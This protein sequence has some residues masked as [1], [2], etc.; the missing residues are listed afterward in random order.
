MDLI[1]NKRFSRTNAV[2]QKATQVWLFS[3]NTECHWEDVIR[4]S[5]AS[6]IYSKFTK[7]KEKKRKKRER[8]H[9]DKS[10][11]LCK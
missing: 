5:P 4:F 10:I 1:V 7:K 6:E 3:S 9:Q 2:P 8:E 11:I